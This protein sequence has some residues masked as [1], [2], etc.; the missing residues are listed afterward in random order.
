[1]QTLDAPVYEVKQDSQWYKDQM[2]R[3]TDID[4]FFKDFGERYGCSD[5]FSFYHSEHFGV[6]ADT[7]AYDFFKTEIVKNPDKN[8]FYAIKK[9]SK[10][11]KEIKS[12][13][14]K[15]KEVYPFKPHDVFGSNN[16]RASQWLD[17]R[18]FYQVKNPEYV[19][20]DEAVPMDY[21]EYLSL[22]MSVIE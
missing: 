19:Q 4:N 15:I 2:Q 6:Q 7:P 1:M 20:G 5:G 9:R 17:G 18:W 13:I 12:Q 10:Y 14:S 16:I 11:F 21:K 22:V 8:G 3:R